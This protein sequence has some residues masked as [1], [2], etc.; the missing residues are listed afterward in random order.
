MSVVN[1][2][3]EQK[4]QFVE[5]GYFILEGAMSQAQIDGIREE[6]TRFMKI[7]DAESARK[8]GKDPNAEKD[9]N[10]A[11]LRYFIANKHKEWESKILTNYIYSELMEDICK[12]TIG[13][14]AYLFNEQFVIKAGE[15]GSPFAWHQDSG[16]I[17]HAHKPYLT[18]WSTV[19]DVTEEN[20]TVYILPYSIGGHPGFIDHV[21]QKD[22]NDYCGYFGDHPGIPVVVPAGSCA[23]FS[24]LTLHRSGR[25]T[26]PNPRR[27]FLSQYSSEPLLNKDGTGPWAFAEPFLKDGQRVVNS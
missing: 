27:V 9:I 8:A 1:I 11:G 13:D 24:S 5:E 12:A 25:N 16:Y 4:Q 23:V 6:A 10:Q 2:T 18:V 19:D 22:S 17:K 14:T 15:K 21:W 3:E 20:G 26:T 7:A